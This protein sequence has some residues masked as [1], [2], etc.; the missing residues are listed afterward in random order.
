MMV[1]DCAQTILKYL[2][3]AGWDMPKSQEMFEILGIWRV[4]S[5]ASTCHY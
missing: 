3:A 4:E 2:L 5:L 1:L